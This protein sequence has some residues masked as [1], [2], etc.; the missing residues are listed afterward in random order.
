MSLFTLIGGI[1]ILLAG[2]LALFMPTML[3]WIVGIGLVVY[4]ILTI[5]S[6]F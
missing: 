3:R 1:V 2:L 6:A 4:G 5:I